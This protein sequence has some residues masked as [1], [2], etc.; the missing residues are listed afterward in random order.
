MKRIHQFYIAAV[1]LSITPVRADLYVHEYAA[2]QKVTLDTATGYYW[3]WNLPDFNYK[4]YD[5]QIT[6]I[7]A[8]GLARISA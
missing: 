4:T 7:A 5:E 2:G 6:D 8:L 1:L 3:Y